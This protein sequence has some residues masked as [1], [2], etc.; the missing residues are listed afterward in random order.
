M[1]FPFQSGPL[2]EPF[3]N[4]WIHCGGKCDDMEAKKRRFTLETIKSAKSLLVVLKD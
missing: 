4:L 2:V 3:F 1:R